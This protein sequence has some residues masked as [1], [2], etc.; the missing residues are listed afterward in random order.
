MKVLVTGGS[1]YFGLLLIKKLLRKGYTV[2]SLDINKSDTFKS[3]V[4]FH[5]VDIRDLESLRKALK[6]YDIIFHNVA[7]VPLAKDKKLFWE[8]NVNGTKN[9]CD[10]SVRNNI[11]KIVYTSSSAVY[12]VPEKN[13]VDENTIPVPAEDYGK[14]KLKG[15]KICEEYSE[16]GLSTSIIRPR[17]ILGH[18]RLG[19]F[20]IL[21]K[22]IMEG[23]NIPVLNNGD[24]IYQFVHAD[25]LADACI[26]SSENNIHF[27]SYNIGAD[28]YGTM[29]ETLENLC[30]YS[31]TGSKVY[32]LPLRPIEIAMN[33]ASKI[34]LSPLG[35][36]HSLM[37]GRSLYFNIDKARRELGFSP[38]FT[39]KQMFRESYDWFINNHKKI[40]VNNKSLHNKPVK[41]HLLKVLRWLS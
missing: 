26:L 5:Q 40:E 9:I 34:K 1:G 36:Y 7:Q 32:S 38:K 14:A 3:K 2:G 8:V 41:E 30:E 27:S 13:P 37:Y 15:E 31:S 28:D 19:I 25:D 35:P 22:W 18:G 33:I 16:N 24:N 11:K 4:K 23:V 21:F 39:T 10:A 6:G 20:S 17:T 12:G 29:R